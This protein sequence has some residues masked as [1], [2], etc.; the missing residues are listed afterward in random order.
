MHGKY[1]AHIGFRF[2]KPEGAGSVTICITFALVLSQSARDLDIV[3][4]A[5]A[6]L[7]TPSMPMILGNS[8]SFILVRSAHWCCAV[9]KRTHRL[10]REFDMW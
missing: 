8:V 10:T 3:V 9:I 5:L 4:E 1:V 6:L 2:R 7:L